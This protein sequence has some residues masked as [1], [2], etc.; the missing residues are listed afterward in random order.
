[1]HR[2]TL[3]RC[4]R[5]ADAHRQPATIGAIGN[6]RPTHRLDEASSHGKAKPYTIAIVGS[7]KGLEYLF[8]RAGGDACAVIDHLDPSA[9]A[10]RHRPDLDGRWASPVT[11]RVFN[12]V[13]EHA[14]EQAAIRADQ[15]QIVRNVD[16]KPAGG[17]RDRDG[18]RRHDL[19]QRH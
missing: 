3:G 18:S 14:L 8:L 17:L 13:D 10:P 15:R 4:E 12:H 7:M 19:V 16:R 1:V 11:K 5:E 2:V 6:H 9:L